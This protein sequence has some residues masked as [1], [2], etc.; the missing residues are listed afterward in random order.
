VGRA[1]KRIAADSS[2]V[3][4]DE[5]VPL[6]LLEN[7]SEKVSGD[8][9][10][11]GHVLK[12]H[13]AALGLFGQDQQPFQR[14]LAFAPEHESNNRLSS[15]REHQALGSASPWGGRINFLAHAAHKSEPVSLESVSGSGI[16]PRVVARNAFLETTEEECERMLD[17]N[18]K[19]LVLCRQG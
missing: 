18:V 13:D 19:G 6:E 9:G 15:C 8:V 7:A 10:G 5:I 4:G 2:P 1:G 11:L 14:V 12:K 17:I 3:G 16:W